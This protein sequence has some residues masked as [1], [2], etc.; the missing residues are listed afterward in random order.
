MRATGGGTGRG[1]VVALLLSLVALP[2]R[3]AWQPDGVDLTRPRIICRADEIDAIRARLD[4]EP[5]KSVLR[6]LLSTVRQ[7]DGT[8]LDDHSINAERIKS[9]AAKNLAVAILFDR[10]LVD[11]A[12]VPF[13]VEARATAVERVRALLV[14]LYPR[15]RLAVPAPLGGWDRDISTAEELQQYATAYDAILAAGVDLDTDDAVIV[16]RLAALAGELY[17]NYVDPSSA[18]NFTTLHQ[19]NHRSK[20]G[21]ALATTAIA[22]ADYTPPPG[23]DP[24]GVH[25]P[26]EWLAYGTAQLDD[27]MRFALVSGDGAYGEGP[28]YMRFAAQNLLP[29]WRAW[30]AL[31][32]GTVPGI[33]MPNYWRHPLLARTVRWLL[34]NTLPDGSLAPTDDGNPAQAFYFGAAP[35]TPATA[36]RWANA[37]P[38]FATDGNASMAAES[39]VNYDDAVL[40]ALPDGSPTAFYAEGGV[41]AL[42]SDWS[43]QSV[44]ALVQAEHGAAA[45]FGRYADGRPASPESHEHPDAGSFLL[46]AFGERLA[47]DPGY[48][49]FTTHA[50]VNKPQDHNMILVD[51]SGP[52][53]PLSASLAWLNDPLAP[54][55]ADGEASLLD[56]LDCDGLDAVAVVTRYGKP[57]ARV[58]RRFLFADDRYLVVADRLDD[59]AAAPR[60]YTWLVHGNGGG[61]S[62]GS[63]TAT[64]S[65]AQ[66]TRPGASL[67]AAL[68]SDSGGLDFTTRDAVHEDIDRASR[69]HTVLE[70]SAT[71]ATARGLMILYPS[72]ADAVLPE[73]AR[74]D[75]PGVAALRLRDAQRRVV[76]WHRTAGSPLTVPAELTEMADATSDGSVAVFDADASRRLHLAWGEEATALIYDGVTL[77]SSDAAGRLGVRLAADRASVIADGAAPQVAVGGLEFLPRAADGACGLGVAGGTGNA[78]LVLGR[79]RRVVLRA[80]AGNSAPA[81]DAGPPLHVAPPQVVGLDGS[82]S[83]DRDGDAL[84]PHWQLISAPG[85]SSWTLDAA[86]TWQP[87]LFVDRA[88]PYRVRLIVTDA[89]GAASQPSEVLIVGGDVCADGLDND[90]DGLF[91]EA[92]ADCDAAGNRAP[93]RRARFA[94]LALAVGAAAELDLIA[95]FE[96][97][98]ADALAYRAA[99]VDAAVAT[100]EI[101]G[102]RAELHARHPGRTQ[103]FV[104]AADGKG[105]A[106][107]ELIVDVAPRTSCIADCD[108]SGSVTVDEILNAVGIGLGQAA[109]DRCRAADADGDDRVVI[110]ELVRA[111]AD[112]LSGC[113]VR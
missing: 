60:R 24:R 16:D 86:D 45:E 58:E 76:A 48:F 75:L 99:S 72:P 7:A 18:G 55:P 57:A 96:D 66:W 12:V 2:V 65:G 91:D 89:H 39:L 70:A 33:E 103:V 74:L 42:R 68:A 10:T 25:E 50:M 22:L 69:T 88:G 54:A 77:L 67:T 53:D 102:E 73:T 64:S 43:S 98:D 85:G 100:V 27:V 20:S 17:E 31:T 19:N 80:A 26:A 51:G 61:T 6:D 105:W 44:L 5:Y 56:T 59:V 104:T 107:N 35:L 109:A 71:A 79:E 49:S 3:A 87:T 62:G 82:A 36:W 40:P 14:N 9:R 1:L 23:S 37:T 34:D 111:V 83:C 84:T 21:A 106:Q 11:G 108:G 47:I 110:D 90:R 38:P 113:A 29:F 52:V 63:F 4:R 112:A 94:D 95:G 81:A 46:H 92:D 15:S 8:A 97:A 101:V 28:F 93:Q 30:D 13:S 41:A 32:G 78:T